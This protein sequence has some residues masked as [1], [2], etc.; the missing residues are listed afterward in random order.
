M[1]KRANIPTSNAPAEPEM[2][3]L[4]PTIGSLRVALG[5]SARSERAGREKQESAKFWCPEVETLFLRAG[6]QGRRVRQQRRPLEAR[7][8][9]VRGRGSRLGLAHGL[10]AV[11]HVVQPEH[12]CAD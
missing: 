11:A 8:P 6:A 3:R 5:L 1:T 4:S 12:G 7:W 9:G 2:S 10:K